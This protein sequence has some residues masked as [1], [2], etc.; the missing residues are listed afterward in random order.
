MIAW[1]TRESTPVKT[2][3]QFLGML[4]GSFIEGR[5][6]SPSSI[7]SNCTISSILVFATYAFNGCSGN[8]LK[9]ALEF[10]DH[11]LLPISEELLD[12]RESWTVSAFSKDTKCPPDL[13]FRIRRYTDAGYCFTIEKRSD[14]ILLT[15]TYP[16]VTARRVDGE[17]WEI[18]EY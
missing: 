6:R 1:N 17:E 12:G 18:R 7:L 15:V 9:D 13:D 2:Q 3:A 11:S 5:L 4:Q 10:A 14:Q 8:N 16:G